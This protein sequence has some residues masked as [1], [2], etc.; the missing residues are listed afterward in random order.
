MKGFALLPLMLLLASCTLSVKDP[1]K[2]TCALFGA[3]IIEPEEA[4]KRL[5]LP[6]G[7]VHHPKRFCYQ[8]YHFPW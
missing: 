6:K 5:N 2:E 7:K 4:R 8:Y 1:I 3:G